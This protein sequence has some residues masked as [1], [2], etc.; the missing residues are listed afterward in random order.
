MK[1]RDFMQLMAATGLTLVNPIASR[2]AFA[3]DPDNFVVTVMASGGWDA[4]MFCDPKGNTPQGGN[5]FINPFAKDDIKSAAQGSPIKYAPIVS[6]QTDTGSFD[7]LF[8]SHH[9]KMVVLNGIKVSGS[10]GYGLQDASAGSSV[11]PTIGAMV[12]ASH[13]TN[14][15]NGFISFGGSGGG[16]N[17]FGAAAI[18]RISDIDS[19]NL[20]SQTNSYQSQSVYDLVDQAKRKSAQNLQTQLSLPSRRRATGQL[21]NA[22]NSTASISSLV[23]YI[24]GT[25]ADGMVGQAELISAGFASGMSVAGNIKISPFDSHSGNDGTQSKYLQEVASAVNR[26]WEMAAQYGYE[27]KLT[28]IMLSEGG[29]GPFYNSDQG[30]D[31]I[32]ETSMVIMNS[33][34]AGNRVVQA[35]DDAYG[36]H[37]LNP[38]THQMDESGEIIAPKHIHKELRQLLGINSLLVDKYPLDGADFNLLGL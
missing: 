19:I 22:M 7:T 23:S 2:S 27:D 38:N 5:G 14:L 26:L 3:A 33:R 15:S 24:P 32:G 10:H 34:I 16:D 36:V 13:G 37:A 25:I 6:G 35:T 17:P 8:T 30:K 29:R 1:R 18:T 21:F 20:L 28:V 12:A 11:Y 31:D 4:T 9:N